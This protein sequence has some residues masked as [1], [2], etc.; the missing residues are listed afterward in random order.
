MACRSW[1]CK[2]MPRGVITFSGFRIAPRFIQSEAIFS[3]VSFPYWQPGLSEVPIGEPCISRY[4]GQVRRDGHRRVG[5]L[6]GP[7]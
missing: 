2:T 6:D 4:F 7:G 1:T 3:L 5:T